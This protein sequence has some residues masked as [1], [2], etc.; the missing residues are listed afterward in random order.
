M[1]VGSLASAY[2]PCCYYRIDSDDP[3]NQKCCTKKKCKS[4]CKSV[5][6]FMFSTIGLVL[7][8]V[9]YSIGGGFLFQMIEEGK[10]EDNIRLGRSLVENHTTESLEHLWRITQ[11]LNILYKDNWTAEA[12]EVLL[13]YQV[14]KP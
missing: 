6:A 4:C 14:C 3:E 9:A 12:K 13:D 10:E 7:M 2:D 1:R 8:V 5:T 11:Q